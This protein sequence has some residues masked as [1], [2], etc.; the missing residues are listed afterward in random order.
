MSARMTLLLALMLTLPLA[1]G[2]PRSL[3]Q[4]PLL[5]ETGQFHG[6]E[7]AARR[8]QV[9]L[10]LYVN[11][12]E[13]VLRYSKIRVRTV[14]DD[15]TDHGSKRKTGK[16]VSVSGPHKPVFLT[17]AGT[18][19]IPGSVISV[20]DQKKL[21]PEQTLEKGPVRLKLGRRTYV[22]K[23]IS[24][25]KNPSPCRDQAFPRNAKLVL[26]TGK[27]SQTLYTLDDC[28]NDPYWYLVWAGD[29]D[30]DGKLDLYV[31]VTQHYDVSERRLF[32]S[33]PARRGRL[34]KEV[35]AFVTGGC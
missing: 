11:G 12:H 33:A 15:V 23:V 21:N 1:V 6:D 10:G 5:I 26:V 4:R 35:A 17:R 14:F 16:S 31:D 22:L 32:L 29:L 13:A 30:R 3:R 19:L 20:F 8:G 9:W 24:P 25:D 18:G 7:I 28:G 27:S 2:F 34:V